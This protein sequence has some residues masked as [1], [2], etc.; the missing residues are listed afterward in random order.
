M[1]PRDGDDPSEP[2]YKGGASAGWRGVL[3]WFGTE[4][5]ILLRAGSEP[6]E[7]AAA[8]RVQFGH[9]VSIL[10]GRLQRSAPSP[11]APDHAFI[12]RERAAGVEPA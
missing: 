9:E 8:S 10:A 12:Y 5:S 11:E 4:V 1:V 3:R 6:G 7:L 2:R